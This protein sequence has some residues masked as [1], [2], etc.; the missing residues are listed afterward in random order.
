MNWIVLAGHLGDDPEE[1]MTPGG[2]KVTS[3]RIACNTRKGGQDETTWYRVTVWG[4]RFDRM[5]PYVKKGSA[6]IVTG[7]LHKP[8][9]YTGKDGEPRV[10]LEVTAENIRFSPFGK[11]GERQQSQQGSAFGNPVSPGASP[12]PAFAADASDDDL[13]F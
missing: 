7:E 12:A 13:P 4:D 2:Q 9:I 11:G 3:F 8:Q 1:R 6:L 10:G 5:M